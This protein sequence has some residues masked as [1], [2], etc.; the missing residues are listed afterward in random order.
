M[1]ITNREKILLSV[2]LILLV[3]NLYLY[4]QAYSTSNRA[5]SP[6]EIDR[7]FVDERIE[8]STIVVHVAGAVR[9]SGIVYME[10]GSR[11]ADAVKA[12]GGAL[13]HAELDR[14]NLARMLNDGERIYIPSKDEE[15]PEAYAGETAA[16][17][18][19][20]V[21]I[22]SAGAAE[23]ETLP[24]IGKVIAQRVIEFREKQGLFKAP[25]DIMKVSGIGP[26]I[27]E[28]IKDKIKVR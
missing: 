13:E 4:F 5:I 3:S 14:I 6:E 15:V 17:A 24:G 27:Y 25:E 1:N 10:A 12:A 7:M 23:L 21:N 2:I 11:V 20:K 22:N 19:G 9:N 8:P 26:K 18:D 16:V 28:G